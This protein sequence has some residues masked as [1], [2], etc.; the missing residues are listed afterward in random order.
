MGSE[1]EKRGEGEGEERERERTSLAFLSLG[2]YAAV[3]LRIS[4]VGR[5]LHS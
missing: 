1:K 2:E 5:R 4:Q 3:Y